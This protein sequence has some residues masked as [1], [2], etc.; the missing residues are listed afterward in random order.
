MESFLS[1]SRMHWYH[2]PDDATNVG[3]ASRL[4][5]ERVSASKVPLSAVR[6]GGRRDACPTLRFMGSLHFQL[7]TR[8]GTM[9][10]AVRAASQSF[11][12]EF[13]RTQRPVELEVSVSSKTLR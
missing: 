11:S 7:W 4:P 3:Q 5:S 12:T 10:H 9:N 1:L 8:I 13:W 6:T 2:E